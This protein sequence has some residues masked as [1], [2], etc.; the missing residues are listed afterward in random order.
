MSEGLATGGSV[1]VREPYIL[2]DDYPVEEKP[3]DDYMEERRKELQ[4][5]KYGMTED[6]IYDDV[7]KHIEMMLKLHEGGY[8]I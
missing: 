7:R 5:Q 8:G 2:S 1:K 4:R 3:L 6:E